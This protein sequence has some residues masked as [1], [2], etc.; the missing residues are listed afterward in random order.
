MKKIILLI[1]SFLFVIHIQAQ[2]NEFGLYLGTSYYIGDLNPQNHFGLTQPAGGLIYRYNFNP[3]WT[4][5]VTALYG[6]IQASDAETN[7][8]DPRNL[9]FR[10][11]VVEFS[12]QLELNFLPYFTGSKK[13]NWTP[14]IFGG[15][16]LFNF[17]PK[18][19]LDGEWYELQP[20]GTEGQTT[21]KYSDRELYKLT[22]F[23][24]PFGAGLKI[25]LSN[26]VCIGLEWGIRKTFFDYIDDVSLTYV[27]PDLLFFEN[28]ALAEIFADRSD[29]TLT[30][31][32]GTERG[33][34]R[35]TD[36]Y[37]FAGLTITFVVGKNWGNDCPAHKQFFDYDNFLYY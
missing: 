30:H 32:A 17:N 7:N 19:E 36:W 5:K 22:Q 11:H 4:L 8:N 1:A 6:H 18:A 35:T 21:T 10:S 15:A 12:P 34:S 13:H 20:M 14:Y 37:S 25:S 29:P 27:E 2:R 3:R 24:F 26:S 9:S 31:E 33:N 28:G 23:S 16:A